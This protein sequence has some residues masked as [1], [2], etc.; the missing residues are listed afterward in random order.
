MAA[1]GLPTATGSTGD[2]Q[3]AKEGEGLADERHTANVG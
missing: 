3:G 2:G 1:A